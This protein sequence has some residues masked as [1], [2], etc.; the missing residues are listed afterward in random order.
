M[1]KI[2]NKIAKFVVDALGNA[3][4]IAGYGWV[5]TLIG[6][7]IGFFSGIASTSLVVLGLTIGGV[8][9]TGFGIMTYE[10][11]NKSLKLT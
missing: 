3:L 11:V 4:F 7:N 9:A 1:P 2:N 10:S 8:L 6:K 5:W